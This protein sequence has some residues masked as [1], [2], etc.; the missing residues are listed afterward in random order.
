MSRFT[1]HFEELAEGQSLKGCSE[2]CYIWQCSSQ[3]SSRT[4][5]V[6]CFYQQSGCRKALLASLLMILYQEVLLTVEGQEA[7]QRA[8]DRLEH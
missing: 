6:Q 4:S 5:S 3:L 8:L 7:L 2:W 1:A